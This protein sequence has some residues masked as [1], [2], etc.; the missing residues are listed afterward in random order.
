MSSVSPSVR[1]GVAAGPLET[2]DGAWVAR[3]VRTRSSTAGLFT[4][5]ST[6][7]SRRLDSWLVYAGSDAPTNGSTLPLGLSLKRVSSSV[8]TAARP[9]SHCPSTARPRTAGQV[10]MSPP[11]GALSEYLGYVVAPPIAL[12]PPSSVPPGWGDSPLC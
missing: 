8:Y 1:G 7:C 11:G 3:N 10:T 2:T 12:S 9:G 4:R 6:A 5:T